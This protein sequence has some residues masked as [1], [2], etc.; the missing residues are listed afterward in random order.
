MRA[1]VAVLVAALALASLAIWRD[2]DRP[3]LDRARQLVARDTGFD[4][5]LEAGETLARVAQHLGAAVDECRDAERG[6]SCPALSAALGYSQ[7]LAAFVLECSAPGR[8]EARE[9]MASY[10][11][12]VADVRH[13]SER[14]P[15]PPPLPACQS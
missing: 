7:V 2:H 5:G 11:E 1:G 12:E 14:V 9:R 15:G 4:S 8:F 3:A 6:A 13:D 10:L